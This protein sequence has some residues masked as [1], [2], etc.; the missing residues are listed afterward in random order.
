MTPRERLL[1]AMERGKPDRLPVQV[2]NWMP[3]YLNTYLGGCN[4][5]EAYRR[6]DMD[7]VIYIDP[8]YIY[9]EK[10][11]ANWVRERKDLGLNESGC[12]CWA[13]TITT[14]EGALT[15]KG[16][17]NDITAWETEPLIKNKADFELFR[18]YSPVPVKL[19]F[20]PV[21]QAKD[22]IGDKG[23][24]RCCLWGH[25]QSGPWQSFCCLVGTQEAIF[26]A[27][28]E[29]EWVHYVEQ[30]LTDRQLRVIEMM[31]GMP[32]DLVETGGG[33]GSNT[34]ISPA[35]HKEFCTPYDKQQHDALHRNGTK[36][37]YHLCGGLM[38]QLDNVIANGTDGLE[39]MT[40][41]GMGGD[42]DLA[43]CARRVGDKLFFVG[44]FDQNQGFEHG[45][46]ER[47]KK[48][49]FECHAACPNGGY[50][51]SP[52]D[53]F[54]HGDPANVQAFVDAAKEC[55]YG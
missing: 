45:T 22:K 12:R 50:I 31:N 21:I 13:E 41:P 55:L 38:Q 3:Y 34:V 37:V 14:P 54:F 4:A 8:I 51:C 49:V 40:P 28:D 16:A 35:M 20:A 24:T 52:S 53:H 23:M 11:L 27:I 47:A 15:V 10:D 36:V 7:Y 5:Y 18:K 33:A 42:C 2:H 1:T 6:F 19:D 46:P 30:A 26:F 9:A 43:E 29:P 32:I 48:L 17:Y 25:G 39:T 44:G